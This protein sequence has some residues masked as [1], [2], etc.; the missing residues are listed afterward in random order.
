[1]KKLTLQQRCDLAANPTAKKLFHCMMAKQSNLALS[2]DVT[3]A[4]TLLEL[5]D[6]L[7]PHLCLLKTHIDILNDFS[8][9]VIHR[10]RELADHHHFLIFED[11]KFAD[12]G[13]TVAL[14]YAG[15][16][17]RIAEWAD[18]VNAHSLPG[19]GI[20]QGLASV[21]LAQ[22]RGLLLL[23][24]MSSRGHLMSAEYQQA[25][26]NMALAHPDFVMG[27]ITQHAFT[28]HPAW[29]NLTPGVQFSKSADTLGQQYITPEKAIIH[30]GND[31]IIVGRGILQAQDPLKATQAYQVA[32]W[33][34]LTQP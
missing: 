3:E 14:Q 15:G 5:A 31:I 6:T 26:L 10:L 30:H 34:A 29:I 4:A 21:G 9:T 20:I 32:A 8:P 7:G 33:Q 2:A 12:I 13:H 16:I 22:Q 18:I 28:Q 19:E 1:M 11:R 27:F 24:E 17:Y 23:A 25:T